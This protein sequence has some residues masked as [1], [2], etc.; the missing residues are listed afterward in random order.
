MSRLKNDFNI[1]IKSELLN[2]KLE[3]EAS[4]G[5]RTGSANSS[6][7]MSKKFNLNSG[8]G[9]AKKRQLNPK[10]DCSYEEELYVKGC[11]AI[12]SKGLILPVFSWLLLFKLLVISILHYFFILVGKYVILY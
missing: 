5:S 3:A 8:S 6:S 1:S 12:W 11:T 10:T 4:A 7:N 2:K 9:A